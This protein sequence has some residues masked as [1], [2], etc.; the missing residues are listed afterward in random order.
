MTIIEKR[1][2]KTLFHFVDCYVVARNR[3][4]AAR[5]RERWLRERDEE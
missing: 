2:S 5:A 3:E 1:R 4:H